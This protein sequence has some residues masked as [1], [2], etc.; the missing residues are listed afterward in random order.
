VACETTKSVSGVLTNVEST[1]IA[2]VQAVTLRGEDGSE[3]RY[4]VSGEA[5]RTGHPPSAG[6]LRQHMTHGDRVTLR[7]RETRD[8]PLADEIVDS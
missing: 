8:G 2:D 1:G 4:V 5:A 3:R 6:H 7:Y